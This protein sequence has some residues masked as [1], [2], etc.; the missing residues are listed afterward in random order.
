MPPP[1]LEHMRDADERQQDTTNER[2]H[3]RETSP[4]RAPH[5]RTQEH[6]HE[7]NTQ[8]G[9]VRREAAWARAD[10]THA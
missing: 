1:P 3:Q 5:Q 9:G 4:V 2:H 6:R 7:F 10:G 8:L